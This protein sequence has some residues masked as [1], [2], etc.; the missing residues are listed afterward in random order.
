MKRRL[1]TV[2][3]HKLVVEMYVARCQR[4]NQRC[5]LS[6]AIPNCGSLVHQGS[7]FV[8]ARVIWAEYRE[9]GFDEDRDNL[10]KDDKGNFFIN[11]HGAKVE[12]QKGLRLL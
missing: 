9:I 10:A 12:N 5:K 3:M 7:W 1:L 6:I 4:R 11:K 2:N 8:G